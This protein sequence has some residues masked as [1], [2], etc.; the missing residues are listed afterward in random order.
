MAQPRRK[1]PQSD[2]LRHGQTTLPIKCEHCKDQELSGRR[3]WKWLWTCNDDLQAPPPKGEKPGQHKDQVQSGE[4]QGPQRRRK[5]SSNDR[6]EVCSLLALENQ[7]TEIDVL[8]NSFNTAVTETANKILGKHRPAKKSWVT[9][10]ILKL[11]NKRRELKQK[12]NTTEGAKLYREAKQ[13]VKKGMRKAKET[14]IEEQCQGIEEN[15]QK[16]NRKKAYQLVKELTSFKQ[17][18][19]TTIQE[20]A[21]KC[22]TE[23]QDIPKRWTGFCCELYTHTIGDPKVLDVAPPINN[24]SYPILR[25][26]VEATVKSLK[27]GKSAGVDNIPSELVQ[28][29]GEAMIDMLLIICNKI[30][31]TGEWLTP[32]T[33]SLIITLPKKGNLQLCQNYRTISLISHPSKVM[34]RILRDRL[35]P[36][37]EEII[38]GEQAGFRAG[39]STTE[40]IFNLRILCERYLQHQQS[41]YHVFV[42]F[43][44]AF[45]LAC[46]FVGNHEAV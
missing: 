3:Y 42:D 16:N 27:K 19:T 45:E 7:D 34:L 13:Q 23:E 29:G 14:W 24:D 2:R 41:L 12:K 43:K 21:G 26:E 35:K 44:K 5:F 20:K 1:L 39:R 25:E 32:W 36:Q 11:C 33:Q 31:Q 28:A 8:I 46:S 17:G 10:N 4:T 18:R 30:R 9:D 37:A 40:Q 38:K 15:L 22:L 6:R